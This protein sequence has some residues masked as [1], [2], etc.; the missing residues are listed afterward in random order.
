MRFTQRDEF[1]SVV[2][3]TGASHNLAEAIVR[4]DAATRR[5]NGARAAA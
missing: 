2:S 4:H 5:A 3:V 1:V